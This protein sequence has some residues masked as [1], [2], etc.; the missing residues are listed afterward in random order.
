MTISF[1][2]LVVL[3]VVA[4]LFVAS[5]SNLKIGTI[6]AVTFIVSMLAL[7]CGLI[8][9]LIEVRLSLKAIHVRAELLERELR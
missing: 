7:T 4:L 6:V 9:F 3:I 8:A 5:L 1:T 2:L